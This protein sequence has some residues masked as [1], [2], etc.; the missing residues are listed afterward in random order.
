MEITIERPIC[1]AESDALWTRYEHAPE[2]ILRV[3]GIAT[4]Q[5]RLVARMMLRAAMAVFEEYRKG[6]EGMRREGMTEYY[7][8]LTKEAREELCKEACR[9]WGTRFQKFDSETIFDYEATVKDCEDR[10]A[11]LKGRIAELEAENARLRATK[12]ETPS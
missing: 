3:M 2:M 9:V 10:I 5:D 8:P 7:K 4:S 11:E 1:E 6:T 12:G